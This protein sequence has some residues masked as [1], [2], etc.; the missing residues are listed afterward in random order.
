MTQGC[1][2]L[3]PAYWWVRPGLYFAGCAAGKLVANAGLL[4]YGALTLVL[5]S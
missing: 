3:L 1:T 4:E 2:G 5:I